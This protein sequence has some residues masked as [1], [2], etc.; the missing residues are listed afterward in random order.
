MNKAYI[1]I[2]VLDACVI[3]PAPLRDL[4]LSIA[5]E[6]GF[7]PKWSDQIQA[8]WI[9]NLLLKRPDL[10]KKQ[11]LGTK[12]AME[13]A[14]P[15]ARILKYKHLIATLHLPD[16]KDRHVLAAAIQTRADLIVTFNLKDFPKSTLQSYKLDVLDPDTFL[17]NLFD[18]NT[19]LV[20]LAFKKLCNRL[21]NPTKSESEILAL[22]DQLKCKGFV[23]KLKQT[24]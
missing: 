4:L 21:I 8:E 18:A 1:S 7:I 3:Y 10:T 23:N 22:L 5:A 15:D 20:L 24:L 13:K 14:F 19:A 11:L 16:L 6:G 9:R 17:T 12:R 2:A